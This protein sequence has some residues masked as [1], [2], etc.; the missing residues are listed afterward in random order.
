M[1]RE[2]LSIDDKEIHME[3]KARR[4]DTK[5][6]PRMRMHGKGMKRF[7]KPESKTSDR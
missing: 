7:A 1:K 4:R 3:E 6:Q 2:P 5:R